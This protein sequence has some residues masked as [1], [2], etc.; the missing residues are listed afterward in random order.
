MIELFDFLDYSVYS[1]IR[2]NL[3]HPFNTDQLENT[4][5]AL[6]FLFLDK[7]IKPYRQQVGL[8]QNLLHMGIVLLH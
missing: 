4:F 3:E 1:L 6:F 2:F 8:R 5:V 7:N